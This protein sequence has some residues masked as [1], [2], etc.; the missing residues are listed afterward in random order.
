MEIAS[1]EKYYKQ[2]GIYV[3][4]NNINHKVYIGAACD[5]YKRS[6]QHRRSLMDN[7]HHSIYLQRFVNK[8]GVGHL[9]FE[10]IELC[11]REMLQQREQYYLDKHQSYKNE[12]GFNMCQYAYVCTG[13]KQSPETIKKRI[14]GR[15]GK[16]LT[17][18]HKKK[19][20]DLKIGFIMPRHVI[21]AA[22]KARR[23]KSAT[24]E[25]NK[26]RSAS[27]KITFA[28]KYKELREYKIKNKK[29]HGGQLGRIVSEQTISSILATREA[30]RAINDGNRAARKLIKYNDFVS[31]SFTNEGVRKKELKKMI[32]DFFEVKDHMSR[33]KICEL[34]SMGLIAE[35]GKGKIYTKIV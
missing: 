12:M 29:K 23:G 8:Y 4:K 5:L 9:E 14:Q 3:I 6:S 24:E 20:R 17:E 7:K 26:K 35:V 13:L 34:L 22:V 16:P 31:M 15:L 2:S 32:Q 27:L 30:N 25:E 11:E 10:V 28:R 19:L 33:D 1:R 18:E 21:E